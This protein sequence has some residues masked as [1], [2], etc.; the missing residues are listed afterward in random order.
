MLRRMEGLASAF[1]PITA[2]S[3]DKSASRPFPEA[4]NRS[5]SFLGL[6]PP[7]VVDDGPDADEQAVGK[8]GCPHP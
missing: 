7:V 3:L 5:R 8:T 6:Y 2:I 1:L 4:L